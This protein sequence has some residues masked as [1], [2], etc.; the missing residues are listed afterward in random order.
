MFVAYPQSLQRHPAIQGKTDTTLPFHIIT[1]TPSS[2]I[3]HTKSLGATHV[4]SHREPLKP[5]IEALN[6]GMPIKYVVVFTTVTKDVLDQA[7]DIVAPFGKIGLA[8]QGP[9]GSYD[10]LGAAQKKSISVHWGFVFTK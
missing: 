2:S 7:I 8:V 10:G 4:I 6:L 3:G 5:Q 1:D 9:P